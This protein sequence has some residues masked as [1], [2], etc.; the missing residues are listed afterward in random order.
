MISVGQFIVFVLRIVRQ[1]H[2][3][4]CLEDILVTC[5][6]RVNTYFSFGLSCVGDNSSRMGFHAASAGK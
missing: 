1:L 4:E 5:D 2:G 6:V 3:S